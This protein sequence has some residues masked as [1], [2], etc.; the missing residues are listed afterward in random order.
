MFDL[1]VLPAEDNPGLLKTPAFPLVKIWA[2]VTGHK[3]GPGVIDSLD[4]LL[5]HLKGGSR[6]REGA[7]P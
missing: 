7:S 3:V 1:I 6:L 5:A 2:D 4:W